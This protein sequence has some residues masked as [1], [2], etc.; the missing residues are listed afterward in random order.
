MPT[1]TE[2]RYYTHVAATNKR[3][4]RNFLHRASFREKICDVTCAMIEIRPLPSS[5]HLSGARC[6][7]LP[8][9]LW[10]LCTLLCPSTLAMSTARRWE[11]AEEVKEMFYHSYAG[12]MKYAFPKDELKPV[13]C[14]VFPLPSELYCDATVSIQVMGGCDVMSHRGPS[15]RYD[16]YIMGTSRTIPIW[17]LCS[18]NKVQKHGRSQRYKGRLRGARSKAQR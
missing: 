8:I 10:L 4:L 2:P 15:V 18:S 11:L 3:T 6:M 9:A 1:N 17:L 12:Y 16:V 7:R 5:G 13:S 14:T